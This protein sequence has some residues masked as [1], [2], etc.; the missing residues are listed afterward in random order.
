MIRDRVS[1]TGT[2]DNDEIGKRMKWYGYVQRR[3]DGHM[4]GRKEELQI[5]LCN[6]D[7]KRVEDE[8][9]RTKWKIEIQIYSG[10]HR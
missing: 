8:M 10:N 1:K 6:S 7:M 5:H 9:D 3:E 2:S 4:L